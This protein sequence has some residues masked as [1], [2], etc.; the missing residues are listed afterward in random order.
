MWVQRSEHTKRI[1]CTDI[2]AED[3]RKPW[4]CCLLIFLLPFVMV[5]VRVLL[6]SHGQICFN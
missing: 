3:F 6:E 2:A 1:V 5:W 4:R